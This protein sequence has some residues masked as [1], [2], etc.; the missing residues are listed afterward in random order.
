MYTEAREHGIMILDSPIRD[1]HPTC[2]RHPC[3]HSV[4]GMRWMA[5]VG[6]GGQQLWKDH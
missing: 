5:Q 4:E 2:F 1:R 6:V 3:D